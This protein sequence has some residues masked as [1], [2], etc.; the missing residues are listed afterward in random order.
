MHDA[1]NKYLGST[2]WMFS[3]CVWNA[4][5]VT[6]LVVAVLASAAKGEGKWA[7]RE[8]WRCLDVDPSAGGAI[9]FESVRV[10][11]ACALFFHYLSFRHTNATAHTRPKR[12]DRD[13]L[14]AAGGLA[15]VSALLTSRDEHRQQ[16]NFDA[17]DAV[18]T[19][20]K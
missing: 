6:V 8:H 1:L 17:A 5:R 16:R 20:T 4:L 15:Q 12:K 3:V 14:S 19:T 2:S 7:G 9:D 18:R 13:M 11:H 10:W